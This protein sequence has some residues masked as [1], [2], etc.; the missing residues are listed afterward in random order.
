MASGRSSRRA[1]SRRDDATTQAYHWV[2]AMSIHRIPPLFLIGC[3]AMT[4]DDGLCGD[5]K[6]DP[7]NDLTSITVHECS[8]REY[9][10]EMRMRFDVISVGMISSI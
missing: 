5:S 10:S 4:M 2:V 6:V 7:T 8:Q 1:R 3:G 9:V